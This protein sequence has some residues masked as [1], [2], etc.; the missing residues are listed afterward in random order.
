MK[1]ADGEDEIL[2]VGVIYFF[3]EFLID[4]GGEGFVQT[5]LESLGRFVGD[6]DH[7]L[8]E[9]K[10]ESIVRLTCDP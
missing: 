8:K 4:H 6:F 5:S 10:R 7:F 3:Q 1:V 9:T 2:P